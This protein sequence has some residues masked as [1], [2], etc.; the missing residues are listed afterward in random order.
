MN[1]KSATD[2]LFIRVT[3]HDLASALGVSVA[4]IRQARLSPE[5]EAHRSP[6]EGWERASLRLAENAAAHYERLA[7]KL[8]AAARVKN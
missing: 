8:R 3:Q 2:E 6:P 4:L 7:R 1:F 5:A